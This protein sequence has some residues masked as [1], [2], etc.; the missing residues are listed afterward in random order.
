MLSRWLTLSLL[1][2]LVWEAAQVPLYTVWQS[3]SGPEIA[4]AALHCTAGDVIIS[5]AGFGI[6]AVLLRD[7]E[8]V[9]TRP[10][11]GGAIAIIAGLIYTAYS[12]WRNVYQLGS[13]AYTDAMPLVF[14]IGLA[15]LLQWLLIP[16]ACILLPHK[17]RRRSPLA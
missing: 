16:V 1:L 3:G 14:G 9:L 13:W 2:N 8:W 5:A 11:A 6:A 12:E 7:A 15:P 17:L 4:Y 10:W